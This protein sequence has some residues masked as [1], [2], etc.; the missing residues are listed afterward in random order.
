MEWKYTFVSKE[1]P[2]C[3][4]ILESFRFE[5]KIEYEYEI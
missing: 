1:N 3:Y 4:L 2:D 5:E